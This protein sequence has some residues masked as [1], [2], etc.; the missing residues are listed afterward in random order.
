M[1]GE[2]FKSRLIHSAVLTIMDFVKVSFANGL[3]CK[4]IQCC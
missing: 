4:S 1:G 2:A 3:K